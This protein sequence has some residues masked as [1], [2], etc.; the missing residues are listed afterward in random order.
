MGGAQEPSL[1]GYP[2]GISLTTGVRGIIEGFLASWLLSISLIMYF[3]FGWTFL[4]L[5]GK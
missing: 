3:V 4:D 1:T 5:C 2:T